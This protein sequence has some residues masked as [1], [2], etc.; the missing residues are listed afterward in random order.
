MKKKDIII[1][2][3]VSIVAT[4]VY[5]VIRKLVSIDKTQF[6]DIYFFGMILFACICGRTWFE[7]HKFKAI[8]LLALLKQL[9]IMIF[10]R[11]SFIFRCIN[12]EIG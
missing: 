10:L 9:F 11:K 3:A 2:F 5:D 8:I 6:C 1:S 4:A 7:L 12:Q